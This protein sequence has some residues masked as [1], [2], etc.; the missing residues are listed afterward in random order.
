[1]AAFR[2]PVA[3]QI[4]K[5]IYRHP[6]CLCFVGVKIS[7]SLGPRSVWGASSSMSVVLELLPHSVH[8]FGF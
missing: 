1:L 6:D 5:L 8:S 7:E 4:Q 3:D 2:E